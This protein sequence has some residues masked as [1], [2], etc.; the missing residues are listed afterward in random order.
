MLQPRRN[1]LLVLLLFVLV[2]CLKGFEGD[3]NQT[4]RRRR[5]NEKDL[6]TVLLV[7]SRGRS[8]FGRFLSVKP[9]LG[10][11]TSTARTFIQEGVT[12]EYATQVLGTTLDNGRLYAHLLTKSSR[13]LYDDSPTKAH[14]LSNKRWHLNEN[15]INPQQFIR[16]IDYISPN[17]VDSIQ[18]F[19]TKLGN[20]HIPITNNRYEETLSSPQEIIEEEILKESPSNNFRV[21][22]DDDL[23]NSV[24]IPIQNNVKVFKISPQIRDITQENIIN[25]KET[26]DKPL[27]DN[28]AP[29]KVKPWENLPT[30][31]VRN[32]F[33]PSVSFLGDLPEFEERTER[34]KITTP[35]ERRAKLLFRA[36]LTKPSPKDLT[37]ITYSGFADFTTTVGDTVIIFSPHTTTEI[38]KLAET[39][40]ISVEPILIQPTTTLQEPPLVTQI[41]TFLSLEPP[42]E[43]KTFKGHKLEMKTSIPTMVIDKTDRAREP[44]S[45]ILDEQIDMDAKSSVLAH[46]QG[47]ETES[48]KIAITFSSDVIQPSESQPIMLSTPS[49]EDI[50]NVL[51]SLQALARQSTEPFNRVSTNIPDP[52][53]ETFKDL[54][55][56]GATTIFF[57]DDFPIETSSTTHS[58][59]SKLVEEEISM[60]TDREI[61]T[62]ITTEE[63]SETQPST[64]KKETTT[65]DEILTTSENIISTTPFEVI[66]PDIRKNEDNKFADIVCSDGSKIV[67]STV[68]KTLTY[69]TTFFIPSDGTT[70]TSIKSNE[71]ISSEINYQT[72]LCDQISMLP[73]SETPKPVIDDN[74]TI[75]ETDE[76]TPISDDILEVTEEVISTVEFSETTPQEITT[77]SQYMTE[78]EG[79]STDATTEDGDEVEVIFKTL[80][81]TY[82][83]LTTYFQETTSSVA[84]RIV[85][86]TNVITSTLDP[87][88]DATDDAVSG[89]FDNDR[90]LL[91]KYKSK[92]VTFEDVANMDPS[93]AETVAPTISYNSEEFPTDFQESVLSRPTPILDDNKL[94]QTVNGVKTYYTTYTYFTTIFVDGETEISSRTEVY[95]NYVTPSFQSILDKDIKPTNVASLGEEHTETETKYDDNDY[96]RQKILK[97]NIRAQ[98]NYNTINRK[99]PHDSDNQGDNEIY[100]TSDYKS[101]DKIS[102]SAKQSTEYVTLEREVNSSNSD[103]ITE[104]NIPNLSEYE[105]IATMVTDV[106]SSTS[107]GARR[108][109]DN[110]DKRNV[111]AD[112]QIVSESNNDSEIIPSP[113]LLLQTSYTT[114]TYFT[115]MY[116]GTTSSNV[117]SR[118]ETITN[119]VTQTLTPTQTLSV[120]DLTLPITYFTTFTYW[121]TLYKDG[122]TKI[123]SREKTVSNIETPAIE[124][125]EINES[126]PTSAESSST[127]LPTTSENIVPSSIGDDDLTTYF[128]TYT[129]YTTSYIGDDTVLNSRLETVTN[130]LNNSFELSSNHIGRAVGSGKGNRIEETDDKLKVELPSI[131]S[132]IKPTGLLS[133]LIS[134]LENDGTTT[135]LSTDVYGTYIDGLYAQVLEST[136]FISTNEIKSSPIESVHLNP[137]GVVSI[138]K[139]KIVDAEGVSTLFYTTQAIGT[140]IDNLYAQVIESTSSLAVDEVKKAA[141]P[142]DLPIAH[143]TG[144]VRV[145]EGSIVQNDTTTFYESKVLGTNIDGKYAQI[146][147]STSSFLVGAQVS[148]KPSIVEH[149]I[150]PTPTQAPEKIHSTTNTISP[151]P[152]AIEGSIKDS[153]KED[154]EISSE[155]ND[156][157]EPDEKESG[158]TKYKLSFQSRKRTSTPAIRPFASRQRPTF[159]PK[160]KQSGQST[161][162]TITRSDFTPTVTAVPASKPNRFGGRRSSSG[163]NIIQPTASGGR[164]F[165]RPKSTGSGNGFS[166]TFGSGRRSSSRIQPTISGSSSRRG[167]FRSSSFGVSI[168][169]SSLFGA[170][171]RVRPTLVSGLL[172]SPSSNIVS[173]T[174]SDAENDLTT[175]VTDEP[176]DI[177]EEDNDTTLALQSTTEIS[178]SKRNQNPLLRFRRPPL[179]AR[180]TPRSAAVKT[181]KNLPI[182][183]AT[184]TTSKAKT[185]FN[186]P[187]SLLRPRPNALFPRRG[188]FT[189][190]T[191]A[192]EEEEEDFDDGEDLEEEDEPEEDTDYDS[193][194]INIQIS[195]PPTSQISESGS[196]SRNNVQIQPFF[197]KRSKRDTYSRFRRPTSTTASPE[198]HHQQTEKSQKPSSRG[199]YSNKARNAKTSHS[200]TSSPSNKRSRISPTK[201]NQTRTQFTLRE[202]DKKNNF[203]RPTSSSGRSSKTTTVSRPKPPKLRNNHQTESSAIPRKSSSGNRQNARTNNRA[204]NTQRPRYQN[205]DNIENDN[206]VLPSFDGTITITHQIPMEVTIPVVNGKITEYKN[207]VTAKY[208]TEVLGPLQ[209]STSQNAFGTEV[210]VLLSENTATG[211]N[212]A[213]VITQF[214]L[215]ETPT[216]SIIFTPTYINRRKTSYSHVIP[217]TIYEVEQIVNTIQPALAAQAPLANILLSQLLLGGLQPQQNPLLGLQQ[218]PLVQPTPTTE[219][220]TRTTT[221][222]TTITSE[223]STVIP[224]TFRGKEIF[225]TIIDSSVNVLTAT[226]FLTD[227]VVLTPTLGF[228]GPQLNTA[229]LLPLL[230]Q[231]LQQQQLQQQQ[232]QQQQLQQ[233]Q[234]AVNFLLSQQPANVFNLDQ[235][236]IK[237]L[238]EDQNKLN[239]ALVDSEKLQE[240]EETTVSPRRKTS[241]RGKINKPARVE[242]LKETSIVTL[243]VSGRTPGEFTTVLSTVTIGEE[244]VRKRRE[245]PVQ[246]SKSFTES[247]F[248]TTD[249][250]D[251]LV[252]STEDT[253]LETSETEKETESLESII[254][255]VPKYM[256][257]TPELFNT[258]PTKSK[259]S[260]EKYKIEYVK[261]SKEISNNFLA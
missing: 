12:T 30:F 243:Y 140:Y 4:P 29:S 62:Y 53:K 171:P 3:I 106:R 244:G 202:N 27:F 248:S 237:S 132:T 96:I 141:L 172:R 31:T 197:R 47:Q 250:F 51:A 57:D 144:L 256:T 93:S 99:K 92:T 240:T 164:R 90:S 76:T 21:P 114:F 48:S 34:A 253:S 220:K 122:T 139:G 121:T 11:I 126:V 201:S 168:R 65:E 158:R 77:E 214:I 130:V 88:K 207:I 112:D 118:L 7:D 23:K 46:E 22:F 38:Q 1:F 213:T 86:T 162:A 227:T 159:A 136:S 192:P 183:G 222:I 247:V 56:S 245:V 177:T 173:Q 142:T 78:S 194:L 66:T 104:N 6:T 153:A 43:T 18:V 81:T 127:I 45:E 166:S 179:A 59:S 100:E 32:E 234:P 137:T 119:V 210:K 249:I 74:T 54:S 190:T 228:P 10:L 239:L 102:T 232:L 169:P 150:I 135:I 37:S 80:Y 8:S 84:S 198:N 165:S 224:L 52:P 251:G 35:A 107:E 211:N 28:F 16:N 97:S 5:Q 151:S 63:V 254:G 105:T 236:E 19:P 223:T 14:E 163:V 145:I 58:L 85:V 109:I 257:Q 146:I 209:Y 134:S 155:E 203:K 241:R 178:S 68:Y 15:L 175:I 255:D 9:D 110:V 259:K 128:T 246:P 36:G 193:S 219:F 87:G 226:E 261:A 215:N 133:T 218:P 157:N 98:N 182:K 17:N 95:T 25:H 212:G 42:I 204:K 49:D 154:E 196:L 44:K 170:R 124:A 180:T 115:T 189:T 20:P 217:S 91:S 13:V 125:T 55:V 200:T 181:G 152:V 156:E 94:M 39:T 191:N 129:Y 60:T 225:T 40:K 147:E 242:P 167:G 205:N 75:Q 116:H 233:Q 79:E 70:T 50:A 149:S 230:Q 148:V 252:M 69:L 231:Q 111:L 82:T 83:Y 161:A 117:V 64:F 199:R 67:P 229:L 138:N 208:S 235:S 41:K 176:T 143:R 206:F 103:E 2:D 26:N 216:T 24:D 187:S 195:D 108:V 221:Y 185:T 33:S 260:S 186:R 160:R 131:T 72:R 73:K 113:T 184:K 238:N 101:V 188:L 71:V 89:L 123:T 61:T 258:E 120:E 174:S